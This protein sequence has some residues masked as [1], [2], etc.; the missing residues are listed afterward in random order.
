[1]FKHLSIEI[2]EAT[3]KTV[4]GKRYYFTEEGGIYPSI[5]TVLNASQK[6]QKWLKEWRKSVG[7]DVANYISRTSASRGSSF[8]KICE[9]YIN[10]SSVAHH[11]ESFLPWCMFTQLQ[12]VLDNKLLNIHLLETALWSNK[13]RVAGRVDCIA[14]WNNVLSVIDFKTSKNPK[15]EEYIE[16]YFIQGSAYCE[17]Y[18]ELTGTTINQ[19]VILVVSEDGTVQEFIKDKTE[20]LQPLV[21]TIDSFITQWEQEDEEVSVV[22]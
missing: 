10:N 5:T 14:E 4:K 3:V 6:K 2:P 7:Y 21:E 22:D 18:Q 8:H 1:M 20:Y 15:K 12:P 19:V 17:M 13:Y 16:D 9:D 11:K